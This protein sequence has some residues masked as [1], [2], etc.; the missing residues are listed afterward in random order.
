MKRLFSILLCV[1]ILLSTMC[2][3]VFGAV[4]ET[5]TTVVKYDFE[6]DVN[7]AAGTALT[8][9]AIAGT[10]FEG[11]AGLGTRMYSAVKGST[12]VFRT[13][14]D[15]QATVGTS[16]GFNAG[17][18]NYFAEISF[19]YAYADMS[20]NSPKILVE[21]YHSTTNTNEGT[22]ATL[23]LDPRASKDNIT[24]T[25]KANTNVL[26]GAETVKLSDFSDKNIELEK[27]VYRVRMIFGTVNKTLTI[28]IN[29]KLLCAGNFVTGDNKFNYIKGFKIDTNPFYLDNLEMI[30]YTAA[31]SAAAGYVNKDALIFKIR[32]NAANENAG[33]KT[34]VANALTEY[35]NSASTDDTVAAAIEAIDDA[36]DAS[37]KSP[38][39]IEREA[40]QEMA[41][42]AVTT[43]MISDHSNYITEAS[44][45]LPSTFELTG[46]YAGEVCD[47]TWSSDKPNIINPVSGKVTRVNSNQYV[48][49]TADIGMGEDTDFS[50]TKELTVRV[51]ADGSILIDG[52][53]YKS[54]KLPTATTEKF[55]VSVQGL[56]NTSYTVSCGTKSTYLTAV[57]DIYG[58]ADFEFPI[59]LSTNTE[60]N[61]R[62]TRIWKDSGR[63]TEVVE[64]DNVKL[65]VICVDTN[66][67]VVDS[68]AY[69]YG[70]YELGIPVPE[71]E[72]KSV[73]LLAKEDIAANSA[74]LIVGLYK[75]GI[76]EN[77]SVQPI[78]DAMSIGQKK[79]V[80]LATEIAIPS[81]A[82]TVA[83][84]VMND[85]S[86]LKPLADKKE[87]VVAEAYSAEPVVFVAGDSTAETYGDSWYP[88]QGYGQVLGE[89]I[90]GATVV[91]HAK[92]G[93]SAKSF[94]NDGRLDAIQK[95]MKPGDYLLFEFGHNDDP[96]EVDVY[97]TYLAQY[98][99]AANAVGATPIV[100][101]SVPR[102]ETT[103]GVFNP[104]KGM[105]GDYIEAI[106]GFATD[107]K[108]QMIDLAKY[109]SE[110]YNT[111]K[112]NNDDND[113]AAFAELEKLYMVFEAGS[114]D[115]ENAVAERYTEKASD[116]H[117]HLSEKGA[118]FIA[119][120]IA[121]QLEILSE[122]FTYVPKAK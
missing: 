67:V 119:D 37:T 7:D 53:V 107:Q 48:K 13:K 55:L 89:F 31:N 96:M 106:S 61:K 80:P 43:A 66:T 78:A 8:G 10:D 112:A 15:A 3:V 64:A 97:K 85:L 54:A 87:V 95:S 69:D 19:D 120:Y 86:T 25:D 41:A 42:E 65:T 76:L 9:T 17:T 114:S 98:V 63:D 93:A 79:E 122:D 111:L 100:M 109:V 105:L 28:Y 88:K 26:V 20:D 12:F 14:S 113:A 40:K 52:E 35:N 51:L 59:T 99:A 108:I 60:E 81:T 39:E 16:M 110:Y 91:N 94:I 22:L 73:T 56:A 32:S 83:A 21:T 103:E 34:A 118:D 27:Q 90:S 50:A 38:E 116:D 2:S 84:F 115:F 11:I 49:L 102:C 121:H 18:S 77:A 29:G 47:I 74:T 92:S 23:R 104:N 75:G 1:S 72:L 46:D 62:S 44:I 58:N 6:S 101:T 82:Y 68:F 45:S 70:E 4:T 36:I 57:T 5:A 30:E 24:L 117:T 71:S 33:V